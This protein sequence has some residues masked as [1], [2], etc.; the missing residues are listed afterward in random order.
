MP[1]ADYIDSFFPPSPG[2]SP[3]ASPDPPPGYL[4]QHPLFDQIPSLKADICP[5]PLLTDAPSDTSAPPPCERVPASAPIVSAWFGPGGTVSPL[6][7]DPYHNLLCQVVGSK[8]VRLYDAAETASVYPRSGSLCNNS[9]VD[10]DAPTPAEHPRFAGAPCWQAVLAPG[11][12]L[13]IPRHAWHYVRSLQ[14][15]F[16]TSF[17]FGAKMALVRCQHGSAEGDFKA[18]Y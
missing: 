4:A 13:Y 3:G 7:N 12:M 1:L 17:W 16:S 2:A 15:S 8:Y 18:V 11:E 9:H 10:I 6:H 14:T 5:P